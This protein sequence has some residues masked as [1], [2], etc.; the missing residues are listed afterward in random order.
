MIPG[1]SPAAV[2]GGSGVA[3]QAVSVL[4]PTGVSSISGAAAATRVHA[5][6]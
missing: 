5:G 6:D 3:T 1:R 2:R 4:P